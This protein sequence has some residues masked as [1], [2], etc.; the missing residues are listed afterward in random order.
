MELFHTVLVFLNTAVFFSPP[1]PSI[2][3]TAEL[4]EILPEVDGVE[5]N[6]KSLI[7]SSGGKV[8]K[9]FTA[10]CNALVTRELE[11][12]DKT[13]KRAAGLEIPIVDCEKLIKGETS[14]Y[15][16]PSNAVV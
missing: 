5:Q 3:W 7:Q 15:Q 16:I 4:I 11:A 2:N 9:K 12:D 10:K 14:L 8:F 1:L 6:V 13:I